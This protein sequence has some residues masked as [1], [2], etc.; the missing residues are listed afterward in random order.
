MIK[1]L[2][3]GIAAC[4]FLSSCEF[5]NTNH[6]IDTSDRNNAVRI[7]QVPV[8]GEAIEDDRTL[9]NSSGNPVDTSAS[10]ADSSS[11]VKPSPMILEGHGDKVNATGDK[12]NAH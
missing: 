6:D 9:Y 11:A 4:A 12:H 5:Y 10:A 3:L 2:Y 1:K 8:S 7:Q